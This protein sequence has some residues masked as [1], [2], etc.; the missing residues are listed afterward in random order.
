[1][2]A[3]NFLTRADSE[4]IGELRSRDSSCVVGSL[5]SRGGAMPDS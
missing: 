5:I 1:M 2:K 3:Y 4:C